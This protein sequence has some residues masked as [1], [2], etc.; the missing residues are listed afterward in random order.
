MNENKDYIVLNKN[1]KKA[2]NLIDP[3][4]LSKKLITLVFK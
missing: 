4:V 2:E 1:Q 3:L